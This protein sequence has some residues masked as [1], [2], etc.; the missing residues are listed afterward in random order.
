MSATEQPD[1]LAQIA[2]RLF[3]INENMLYLKRLLDS[4][5]FALNDPEGRIRKA[6]HDVLETYGQLVQF[7]EL[8]SNQRDQTQALADAMSVFLGRMIEHDRRV[9][10][11]HDEALQLLHAF[12]TGVDPAEIARRAQAARD[13]LAAEDVARHAEIELSAEEAKKLISVARMDAIEVVQRAVHEAQDEIATAA[14]EAREQ[15]QQ[16]RDTE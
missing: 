3:A 2:S 10:A 14:G 5:E 12:A 1:D 15:I 16:E 7:R 4:F 9:T 6:L 8:S 11:Q 13:V